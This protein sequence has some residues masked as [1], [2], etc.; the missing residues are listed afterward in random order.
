[1][2]FLKFWEKRADDKR[3]EELKDSI[4]KVHEQQSEVDEL[5]KKA[6]QHSREIERRGDEFAI[7]FKRAIQGR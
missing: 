2:K 7:Q 6:K 5:V 4:D 1:M 3:I